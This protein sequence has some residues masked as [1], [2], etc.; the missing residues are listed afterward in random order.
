[1]RRACRSFAAPTD[2]REWP[3]RERA[4]SLRQ[5]PTLEGVARRAAQLDALDGLIAIGS[6]ARGDADELSDIDLLAV[7]A[8]GRFDEAWAER[9]RLASD[10]LLMWEP[11][12]RPARGIRWFTWLTREVIKIECGIVDPFAGERDLAEP[13]VVL[14]GDDSLADRFPR[15][16]PSELAERRRQR[17]LEQEPPADDAELAYGELIDWKLYE[18]KKAVRRGLNERAV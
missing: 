17:Q 1:M 18:L 14:V 3:G 11:R 2:V 16:S 8:P 6:F 13:F 9:R 10:P 7:V 5:W 4:R 12:S 15:I